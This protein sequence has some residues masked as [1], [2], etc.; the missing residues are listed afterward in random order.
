MGILGSFR[1]QYKNEFSIYEASYKEKNGSYFFL[2]KDTE[3]KYLV[4]I[5]KDDFFKAIEFLKAEEM[6]FN[7]ESYK[8]YFASLKF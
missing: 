2:A 6:L 4:V 3:N 8:L 1:N 7:K 5:T